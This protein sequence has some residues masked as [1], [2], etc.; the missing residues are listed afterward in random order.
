MRQNQSK[1]QK[2]NRT[3]KASASQS[4]IFPNPHKTQKAQAKKKRERQG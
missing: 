4:Q 1:I 3:I 2:S